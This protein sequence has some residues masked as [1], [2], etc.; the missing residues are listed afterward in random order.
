MWFPIPFPLPFPSTLT[1]FLTLADWE[2]VS[3][4]SRVQSQQLRPWFHHDLDRR[5][6]PGLR[7]VCVMTCAVGQRRRLK[8]G[9]IGVGQVFKIQ[10]G[11]ET[12]T[13]PP[14]ARLSN[15]QNTSKWALSADWSVQSHDQIPSSS[16][17][18]LSHTHRKRFV[19]FLQHYQVEENYLF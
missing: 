6:L 3:K 18:R 16:F 8:R 2:T 4:W 7:N 5:Q 9:C 15:L 17:L 19:E 10:H 12:I 1:L 14:P 13:E 11:P